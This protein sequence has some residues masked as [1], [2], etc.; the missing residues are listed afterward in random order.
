[1]SPHEKLSLQ[2]TFL[3]SI[4]WISPEKVLR[5]WLVSLGH[6]A[7]LA[8]SLCGKEGVISGA[9]G[10]KSEW[11][12]PTE[13]PWAMPSKE[14]NLLFLQLR[15]ANPGCPAVLVLQDWLFHACLIILP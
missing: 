11:A 8:K 12:S 13:A 10:Q 7:S 3:S 9:W 2:V 15:M 4:S 5:T 14:A 6:I 1:M